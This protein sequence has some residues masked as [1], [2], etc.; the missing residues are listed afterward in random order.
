MDPS[1]PPSFAFAAL[2]DLSV[3]EVFAG[4]GL[5]IQGVIVVLLGALGWTCWIT[6]RKYGDLARMRRE[7]DAFER[8][9]WSGPSL[10]ELYTSMNAKQTGS[11]PAIFMAAMYEWRRT[12][13]TSARALPGVLERM[14]RLM[15]V[16]VARERNRMEK[17]LVSLS[18]IAGTAPLVGLAG[19]LWGAMRGVL[20]AEG[21]GE[22]M[23]PAVAQGLLAGAVGLL[24]GAAALAAHRALM[25]T[26][27]CHERRMKNFAQEFSAIVS[28]QI[29][30]R[31]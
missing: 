18:I 21:G 8:L 29:E 19:A 1:H 4:G 24:A 17:G 15:A 12:M 20:A 31:A 26:A 27:R 5:M 6:L 10:D 25:R 3:I 28:R 2:L 11:L 14:E 9:F 23:A 13:E 7:A 22:A 16:S 30:P